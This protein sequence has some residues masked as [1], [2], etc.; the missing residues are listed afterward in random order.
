VSTALDRVDS[1]Q[2]W[3]S[4][5]TS[6]ERS[7]HRLRIL[8][9]DTERCLSDLHRDYECLAV[10]A[11]GFER[12]AGES[13]TYQERRVA[14]LVMAGRTDAE[15]AALLQLSVH[16]VKS[17]VKNILR[18]LGLRSRW[19]LPDVLISIDPGTEALR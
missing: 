10:A 11:R 16:T 8:V 4:L 17:H 3:N 5:A 2:E 13:L 12:P 9:G 14:M 7:L 19:Q 18:K 15:T 1:H 6:L